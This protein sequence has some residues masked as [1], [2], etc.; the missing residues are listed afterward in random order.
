M[1]PEGKHLV[2]ESGG[3]WNKCVIRLEDG[4]RWLTAPARE[5]V[6]APRIER[7]HPAL[8]TLRQAKMLSASQ[9][10][11]TNYKRASWKPTSGR[12]HCRRG[13]GVRRTGYGRGPR[14]PRP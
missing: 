14:S 3:S 7:W 8:R 10:V 9:T 12:R 2:L 5:V 1:A 11:E 4:P 13:R 6:D